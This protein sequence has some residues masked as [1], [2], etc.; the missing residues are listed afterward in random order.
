MA[1]QKL[2]VVGCNTTQFHDMSIKKRMLVSA[3]CSNANKDIESIRKENER[4]NVE[5]HFNFCI[6]TS[7]ATWTSFHKQQFHLATQCNEQPCWPSAEKPR[8]ALKDEAGK[9]CVCVSWQS[10]VFRRTTVRKIGLPIV[11][12][13]DIET[14]QDRE[15]ERE[16]EWGSEGVREW[17]SEG[18]S[19]SC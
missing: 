5:N 18:V 14:A 3:G 19:D 10:E 17:G 9:V 1:S 8:N 15:K 12:Y 4:G 7:L 6:Y 13:A 2:V 16:R 11:V